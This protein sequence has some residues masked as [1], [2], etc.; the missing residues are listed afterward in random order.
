MASDA[1]ELDD[2]EDIIVEYPS[3]VISQLMKDADIELKLY[4]LNSDDFATSLR[5]ER[6]AFEAYAEYDSFQ[7]A[8]ALRRATSSVHCT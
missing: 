5:Q 4:I 2:E 6:R 1:L 7:N 8:Q 3:W